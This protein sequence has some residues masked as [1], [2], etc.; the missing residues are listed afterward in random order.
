VV[1]LGEAG[2]NFGAGFTGGMAF[3]YDENGTFEQRINPDTLLWNR[4]I[5]RNGRRCC[6]GWWRPMRARRTAATPR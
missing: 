2:D 4:V 5:D 1:I 6:A 3:V